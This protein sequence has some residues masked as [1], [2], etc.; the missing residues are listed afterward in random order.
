MY[1]NEIEMYWDKIITSY[2][3]LKLSLFNSNIIPSYHVYLIMNS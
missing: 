2:I 1:E 3:K